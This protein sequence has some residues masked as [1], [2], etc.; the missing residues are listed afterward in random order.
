[1]IRYIQFI[2]W[3]CF[4][5]LVKLSKPRKFRIPHLDP[6]TV[7]IV[8]NYC[9]TKLLDAALI[10]YTDAGMMI[11]AAKYFRCTDIIELMKYRRAK[12][13]R[14][15]KKEMQQKLKKIKQIFLRQATR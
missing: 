11:K 14:K 10:P 6:T 4:R 2:N 8:V 12:L 13:A 3:I 7:H 15:A 1:M 9:Y 5:G